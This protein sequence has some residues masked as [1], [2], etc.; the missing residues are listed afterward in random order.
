MHQN[1]HQ[2]Q[3]SSNGAAA[4]AAAIELAQNG[5]PQHGRVVCYRCPEVLVTPRGS[6]LLASW[7][8]RCL[9]DKQVNQCGFQLSGSWTKDV[10]RD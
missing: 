2:I 10:A 7:S 4:A 8:T 9:Q 6:A 3:N 5:H 1:M